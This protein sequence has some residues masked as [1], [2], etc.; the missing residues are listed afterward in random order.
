MAKVNAIVNNFT[1]GEVSQRIWARPE[2]S[3][4]KNGCRALEN[5]IVAVQGGAYKRSGTQHV[6]EL[7]STDRH[8]FIRFQ[9]ST[10]QSYML[11]FGNNF[12][13][14]CKD[15]GIITHSA[16]TITGITQANPAVVT[17]ASH[18][19]SNGDKVYVTSVAGMTEVNNRWFTVAN[20]STNTFELSGVDSSGYTA[21]SSGGNAGEIV[22]LTTTYTTAQIQK[23]QVVTVRDVMY[24]VHPAHPIRKLSR[25]SDTSWTLTEPSITTGPFRT[26]NADDTLTMTPSSF[27]TSVTAFGTY[28]VGTTFTMTAAS[29][30]FTSDMVGGYFRLYEEGGGSGIAGAALGDS[31]KS[32]ASGNVYTYQGNIY[33]ISNLTGASNWAT[34]NRVPEHTSGTV[35]V[36][37]SSSGTVYFDSNFLHPGY[38]VMQITAYTSSTQVTATIVRYQMPESIAGETKTISG[39]T[40]ANPGV[41]TTS[42]AHG[43]ANGDVV[44]LE[45]VVGM[46]EVNNVA[47]TVANVASTTFE[48]SGVDT[49]GYT[50]YSSGGSVRFNGATTYWQEGA[51][52]D[53]RGFPNAIT[54]FEQRLFTGG[55]DYDPTVIWGT[56]SGTFE[57]FEDGDDD[58][59]A[60][61]YRLPAGQGDII[62]WMSGRRAL[63]SGTSSGEFAIAASSQQEALSPS[64]VKATQQTD[65]G[66]A[67]VLPVHVDQA[68]LYCEREGEPDNASL[69][70]REFAYSFSDDRF[71]SV[72][73]TVFS[74][75][76]LGEGAIKVAYQRTPERLIWVLRSDGELA[77]MTYQREQEV[78]PWHRHALAGTG[79][80][81]KE[82][83][84]TA[85]VDSDE[86][87]C[88]VNRTIDGGTV[89]YVEVLGKRFRE[90]VDAK[91]DAKL[92]DSH[93][94]YSGSETS[95]ITGLW[96]LRGEDVTMLING[97][98]ETGTV[99]ATGSLTLPVAGTTV[100]IGYPYT[101]VIE[102]TEIEAGAQAGT[103][104][105]RSKRVSQVYVRVIQSLGGK[106]RVRN[107]DEP[108]AANQLSAGKSLVYRVE[109]DPMDTSP[110]LKDGYIELDTDGG[111]GKEVAIRIEHDEPLPFYLS[112]IVVEQSV[113]G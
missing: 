23:L 108:N 84:V 15:K 50:A 62:R 18:N 25:L 34:F 95:T 10:E 63:I 26:I 22:E 16:K 107:A 64:N 113:T 100:T 11:V 54:L 41:V 102:P 106:V 76:I 80:L 12:V 5:A 101:M 111:W 39:I 1:G 52:S 91:A 35:R 103:A 69:R 96:H 53:Y 79:A 59:D 112:G 65:V 81:I 24:I 71:N 51:W 92:L 33:G 36:H 75:H 48:L 20:Q 60:L 70:L 77:S 4:V 83:E 109:A 2:V 93:L 90:N 42:T 44:T 45:S 74:E 89:A 58:D 30:Y 82:I 105:S 31:T 13:W 21:Y 32:L 37:G 9:Y 56:R 67:N 98:V 40:Q 46:T 94:T 29:A 57:D 66:S 61:A 14:F 72:D 110:P 38:C 86:L 99:S 88:Q 49:S 47:F 87:W 7:P 17:S 73:L 8:R 43:L 104:Q 55:T 19:F 28:T 85:G 6:V 27:D 97:A 78:V 3:K 68:V